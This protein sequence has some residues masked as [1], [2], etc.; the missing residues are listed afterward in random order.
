MISNKAKNLTKN[1]QNL[2]STI[3]GM[4]RKVMGTNNIVM[5]NTRRLKRQL[6]KD[7]KSDSYLIS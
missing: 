6:E 2:V 5:T 3:D 7:E 1:V 4:D